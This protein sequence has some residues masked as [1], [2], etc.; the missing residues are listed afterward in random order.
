MIPID[1]YGNIETAWCPGCGNHAILGAVKKALSRLELAPHQVLLCSG[2]GQAAKAPHYLRCNC[3][4]GL[5]GRGLPPAQGAALANPGLAVIA[6]SGD[7]C[8]YGEGGNHFLAAMRR[9]VG[10]TLLVHDNQ[11]YGLTKGQASPTT[12]QGQVTKFQPGGAPSLAFPPLAV[13]VTLDV[14]FVA[15]GFSGDP[16][17][18]AGLI[19]Q[20]V[21][22]PG[23]ALVDIL[24]PCVSFNKVNTFAWYKSRC[25]KLGPE[26]DPTDRRAALD[27]AL[28]FG[29]RIPLGV[30]YR[31][32][33]APYRPDPRVRRPLA[34]SRPDLVKL[35][36]ILEE[37]A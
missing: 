14:P 12:A 19:E 33:R 31:G 22:H 17:H 10:M 32:E 18:L 26:H 25:Y 9:N 5:H 30:V 34:T 20:A 8:S 2:I 37:Y 36:K 29:E 3:F 35:A 23:F 11:I 7:G 1:R 28:E 21:R 13:A 24:Q 15:R 16:E 27:K 4:N 6:E